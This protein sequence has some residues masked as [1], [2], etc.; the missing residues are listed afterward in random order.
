MNFTWLKTF[1]L[2][3]FKFDSWITNHQ[4]LNRTL[5]KHMSMNHLVQSVYI[6]WDVT[7]R[8]VVQKT[9]QYTGSTEEFRSRFNNCRWAHRNFLRSKK[10]KQESF[11]TH[12]TEGVSQGV[13]DWEIRL[14]HQTENVIDLLW[15]GSYW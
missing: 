13:T 12:F 7:Y 2:W 15:W 1:H 10:V 3:N 14:I 11:P 4:S 8:L 6:P 5:P 9:G